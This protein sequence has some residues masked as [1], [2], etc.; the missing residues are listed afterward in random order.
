MILNNNQKNTATCIHSS[1]FSRFF[2]PFRNFI[3]PIFLWVANKDKSEFI[4]K[5]GKQV[6]NFQISVLLCAIILGIINGIDFIYFNVFNS[7]VFSVGKPF[8]L[9][10]TGDDL[11]AIAINIFFIELALIVLASLKARDGKLFNYPLTINF[12]K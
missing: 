4:D 6:I 10:Y 11:G 3:G 12:L 9:L 8:R 2:I 5:H 1:T 7:L